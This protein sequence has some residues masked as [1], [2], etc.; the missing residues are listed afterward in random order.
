MSILKSSV[1]AILFAAL[2]LNLSTLWAMREIGRGKPVNAGYFCAIITSG[3]M[4]PAFSVNDL[5]FFK[6]A[7]SY[8]EKDT[9]AF[10][11]PRGS[12]ITH[13]IQVVLD[14]GY[15]VQGDANN[16]SDGEID[17]QRVLGKVFFAVP[18]VG[19]LLAG[20]LSPIG[21]ALIGCI[22]SLAWLIRRIRRNQ[23]EMDSGDTPKVSD[24]PS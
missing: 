20:I 16:I 8:K 12:L 21:V 10:V 11:S 17:A 1:I 24:S 2:F 22:L 19:G 13:R 23:N 7:D 15:I 5:L 9:V 14:E 3:S 4:E 6:A 18:N